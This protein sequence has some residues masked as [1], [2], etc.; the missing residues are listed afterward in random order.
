MRWP[1]SSSR[2]ATER[3]ADPAASLCCLTLMSVSK[4]TLNLFATAAFAVASAGIMAWALKNP[5][6]AHQATKFVADQ[7]GITLPSQRP[8]QHVANRDENSKSP[9]TS[10]SGVT[11]EALDN[12]HFETT[13]EING[14]DVS[15]ML[16]TGASMVALTY[17]DAR[18]AGL[19][20]TDADF[21][22][23]SSTANGIARVAPVT[24]SK[25]TVGDIT[26]RNVRGAV[27]E[28]GKMQQ[29]L[30]G[31]SFLSKLKVE[32]SDGAMVLRE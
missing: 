5:E 3:L 18:R 12:G 26:V 15:V 11:L 23:K 14:R 10:S 6:D 8:G 29:T 31:M 30:L 16:D 19:R 1:A 32:M 25:I 13:A 21:T 22:H 27:L 17:E 20:V 7:I 24:I 28:K 9:K 2:C 4:A